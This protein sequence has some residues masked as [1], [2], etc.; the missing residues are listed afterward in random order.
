MKRRT[1]TYLAAIAAVGVTVGVSLALKADPNGP[2]DVS[3]ETSP[4]AHTATYSCEYPATTVEDFCSMLEVDNV[5]TRY[6]LFRA[7]DTAVRT[8]IYDPG[9]P[10]VSILSRHMGDIEAIVADAHERRYNL[11][12]IDEPWVVAEYR[13]ECRTAMSGYFASA[14]DRYPALADASLVDAVRGECLDE[15]APAVMT[16]ERYRQIIAEIEQTENVH[17]ERL[18]GY[19]FASVRAAYLGSTHPDLVVAVGTP[20]PVGAP[21]TAF[22]GATSS[23]PTPAGLNTGTLASDSAAAY[24]Q[25]TGLTTDDIDPTVAGRALWQTDS[26]GQVSLSRVGYLSEMCRSLTEWDKMSADTLGNP[27]LNAQRS[28]HAACNG[29][30]LDTQMTLPERTCFTVLS[31]DIQTPWV[32]SE[33]TAEARIDVSEAGKHGLVDIPTCN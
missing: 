8:M 17:V 31:N 5:Q 21:A 19:S 9:G 13:D 22:F 32:E 24:Y 15:Q 29:F 3:A 33:L 10:G 14:T 11:L 1:I 30:D 6:A 16:G 4:A 25:M 27:M 12:V 20:F 18:E 2:P 26:D 28:M 23:S 7:D